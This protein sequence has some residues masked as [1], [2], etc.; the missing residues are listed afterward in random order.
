MAEGALDLSDSG[1]RKMTGSC[2][3]RNVH[4]DFKKRGVFHE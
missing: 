2:G 4:L 1:Q 3:S